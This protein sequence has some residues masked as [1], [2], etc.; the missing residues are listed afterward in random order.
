ML[1]SAALIVRDEGAHLDD[2]LTSI[3]DLV[4]EIVVVDTGS[5]DDSVVIAERHQAV[6]AHEP[7]RDDF[8]TPRNRSLD[9]ASGEWIL[10]IDADERVAPGDHAA[11]REMLAAS[12]DHVAY[13]ARFIP[14]VG[15]TP[16]HEYRL[17]RNH[18]E[19]RF[20]GGIHEMI[21]P[22][23]HAVADRDGLLVSKTDVLTIEHVGYE[24]DQE[25]KYDRD[26]PMLLAGLDAHPERI[27]YYDHLARIYE[28]RGESDRAVAIWKRGID[29]VRARGGSQHDDRLVY[30]DLIVHLLARRETGDEFGS[31]VAEALDRFPSVPPLELAAGSHEFATERVERARARA[32][33]LTSLSP[34]EV[35]ATGS[36][37]DARV[38]GEWAWNL[39]G[40]CRFELG[41][42][43]GAA[44]AF[45]R[46][47]AAAPDNPAY[48]VRRRLAEARAAAAHVSSR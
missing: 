45:G 44:D 17:F 15:W 4:D 1:L 25:H 21:V 35:V 46:A 37:Y 18:P 2:C 43:A 48:G 40:L 28:G 7:W 13:R 5:T 16:F 33:W 36:S 24:G 42:D 10:Y 6:V 14:R 8:A 26:E 20:R 27:F 34:D 29:A 9:L 22:A 11:V 32:E 31:L 38:L 23:V 39:L 47:E 19:I 12:S 30:I 3:A 41:D